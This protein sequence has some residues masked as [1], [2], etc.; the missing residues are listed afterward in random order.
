[1][2]A[3][4]SSEADDHREQEAFFA[5]QRKVIN[6][7]LKTNIIL[8]LCIIALFWFAASACDWTHISAD[9]VTVNE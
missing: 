6:S 8:Q 4:D 1:M 9:T 2:V 3:D 7:N 5:N